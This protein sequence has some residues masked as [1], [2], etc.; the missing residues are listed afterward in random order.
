MTLAGTTNLNAATPAAPT[1]RQNVAFA[2]DSGSPTVNVSAVDP[3]MTPDTGSGGL[4]GNAPAPGAG[5]AAAGKFLKAD[6]TWAVPSG[7]GG[8]GSAVMSVSLPNEGT[9]GTGINLLA[10]WSQ[11]TYAQQTVKKSPASGSNGTDNAPPLVGVVIAGAGTSGQ[12]TVAYAGP[13]SLIC[14]NTVS[15]PGYW[16]QPSTSVDGQGHQATGSFPPAPNE[17]PEGNTVLGYVI[18]G[19]TGPGTAAMVMLMPYPG[20]TPPEGGTPFL[21]AV[22]PGSPFQSASHWTQQ[23]SSA[24]MPYALTGLGLYLAQVA[25]HAN[26]TRLGQSTLGSSG[27]DTLLDLLSNGFGAPPDEMLR[28]NGSSYNVPDV[29]TSVSG[30]VSVGAVG[31]FIIGNTGGVFIWTLA[32]NAGTYTPS[33]DNPGH[34]LFFT[35]K[36][37]ASGGPYTFTFDA[38]FKNPPTISLSAGADPVACGFMFDGTQYN[39]I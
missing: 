39:R 24:D 3:V 37:P 14:D 19:N 22:G 33:D 20:Y 31:Q 21:V 32:G 38:L 17:N 30:Q 11:S 7:G 23:P 4:A 9:T 5:D 25:G 29:R 18:S 34:V 8:G 27:R 36:P 10:S 28:I 13:V 15:V 2:D 1:G 12:A 16:I 35:I 26:A 6:A